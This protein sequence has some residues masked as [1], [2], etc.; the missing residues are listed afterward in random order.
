M[1]AD[2]GGILCKAP[3]WKLSFLL[4]IKM[5]QKPGYKNKEYDAIF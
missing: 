2:E 3:G 1:V 4:K 5:K